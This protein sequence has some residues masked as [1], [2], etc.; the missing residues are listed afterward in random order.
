MAR[1][2]RMETMSQLTVTKRRRVTLPRHVLEHLGVQ[3]GRE[4][5]IEKLPAGV[6]M[7]GAPRPRGTGSLDAFIG[8][9]AGKTTKVAT[10]E[11]IEE[12]TQA[13]RA[14]EIS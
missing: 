12:A 14:G 6:L 13:G 4:I 2:P 10:L 9:F 7:L 11:E 3:A 8:M 1:V 5:E